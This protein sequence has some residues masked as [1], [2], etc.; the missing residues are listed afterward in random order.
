MRRLPLYL[1][2]EHHIIGDLVRLATQFDV[3]PGDQIVFTDG[4]RATV[5]GVTQTDAGTRIKLG[6]DP[7]C[8]PRP[9]SGK[10]APLWEDDG[11]TPW[12]PK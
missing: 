10:E 3:K 6:E 9:H 8:G 1:E 4:S 2:E 7:T 11:V 5:N 12:R